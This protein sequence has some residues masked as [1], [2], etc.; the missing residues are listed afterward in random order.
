[1]TVS[2]SLTAQAGT[3]RVEFFLNAVDDVS[4]P[5]GR[6]FLGSREVVLAV[7]GATVSDTF[8]YTP[9]EAVLERGRLAA[10]P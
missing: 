4:L 10:G 6:F 7:D 8:S 5:Q 2:F 3:Y 1:M 9:C